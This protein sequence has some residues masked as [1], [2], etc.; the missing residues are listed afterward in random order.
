VHRVCGDEAVAA[1][2]FHLDH[3]EIMDV[4]KVLSDTLIGVLRT[5]APQDEI[6]RG[7][8]A[9]LAGDM[10]RQDELTLVPFDLNLGHSQVYITSPK[11]WRR[12]TYPFVPDVQ[13]MPADMIEEASRV[14]CIEKGNG[15]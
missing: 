9:N 4:I 10:A 13:V 12:S 8:N 2:E 7:A 14:N 3:D 1:D 5:A 6:S 11:A 15:C